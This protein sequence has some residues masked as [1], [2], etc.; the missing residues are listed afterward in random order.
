MSIDHQ[1]EPK[2]SH[3]LGI[4]FGT[5]KVGLAVADSELKI[6]SAL[7]TIPN[8][9]NFLAEL[10]KIIEEN[11]ISRIIFGVTDYNSQK[12]DKKQ[13]GKMIA[14]KTGISL[15]FWNEMFTTK[16]AQENIKETGAKN[17]KRLD[18]QEAA[19]IILQEW[20]DTQNT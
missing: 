15:E 14:E 5:S 2:T 8:D 7:K 17:I 1:K 12:D 18:N 4:D 16:M 3:Y 10:Q 11:K 6:A 9:Q 13:T 20:L 19:R